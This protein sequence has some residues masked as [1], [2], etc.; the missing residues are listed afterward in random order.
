MAKR[1]DYEPDPIGDIT[2]AMR[3]DYPQSAI[4]DWKKTQARLEELSTSMPLKKIVSG[5]Q[6]GADFAGL[7]AAKMLGLE[8]GGYINKGCRRLD[9]FKPQFV[10]EFGLTELDDPYYPARTVANVK[11]SDGTVRFATDFTTRGERCTMNA[12]RRFNRPYLDI[13]LM[14]ANGAPGALALFIQKHRIRT[15]NVAGNAIVEPGCRA[16]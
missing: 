5:C 8:T 3:W 9:G 15:L 16:N 11:N 6:V 10:T 14:L 12:I 1:W 2:N 7:T 13:D 4:D